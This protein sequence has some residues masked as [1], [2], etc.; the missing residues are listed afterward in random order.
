[1]KQLCAVLLFWE[2]LNKAR[3]MALHAICRKI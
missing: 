3:L 1:M 2:T